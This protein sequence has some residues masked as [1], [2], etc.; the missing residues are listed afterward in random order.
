MDGFDLWVARR[1]A[2][3]H[4]SGE[5]V[6]LDVAEPRVDRLG[7]PSQCGLVCGGVSVPD[8]TQL[9]V[10]AL[11]QT[12]V[13]LLLGR[14]VVVDDRRCDARSPGDLLERRAPITPLGEHL[15]RRDLDGLSA[16]V[17]SHAL[18][19]RLRSC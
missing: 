5:A 9:C 4:P 16:R 1:V 10:V 14:E 12:L 13:Q 6:R 8:V 11:E 7:D 17:R 3:E 19:R 18:A 15:R 2:E